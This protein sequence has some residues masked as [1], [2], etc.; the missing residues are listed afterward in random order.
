MLNAYAVLIFRHDEETQIEETKTHDQAMSH[1]DHYAG[2][3][4]NNFKSGET[5]STV[6][7]C[8]ITTDNLYEKMFQCDRT[9][10]RDEVDATICSI[11]DVDDYEDD[12]DYAFRTTVQNMHS[13]YHRR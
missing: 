3:M 11:S 2:K 5:I 6:R 13:I 1:Y 9:M 8:K 7:M 12:G 4:L 10:N